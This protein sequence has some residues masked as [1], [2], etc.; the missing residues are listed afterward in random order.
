MPL[1]RAIAVAPLQ[2]VQQ[3]PLDGGPTTDGVPTVA[4]ARAALVEILR[5][6]EFQPPAE[7]LLSRVLEQLQTW[8]DEFFQWLFQKLG[9]GGEAVETVGWIV[10]GLIGLGLAL[11]LYFVVRSLLRAARDGR[12]RGGDEPPGLTVGDAAS[13]RA[14]AALDAARRA[15]ERGD[16]A[17]AMDALYLGVLYHLDGVG[18]LRF[19]ERKTAGEYAREFGAPDQRGTWR[20]LVGAFQP[21]AFG[22]RPP[23]D[24][25]WRSMRAAADELG[26]PR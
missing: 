23:T 21:V 16:L 12:G 6:P 26:V 14:R 22:G 25:A 10:L 1:I 15:A 5:A 4:E 9:L 17:A 3:L 18:R 13:A 19:A 11:V 7:T 2:R 24:S 20:S 8:R